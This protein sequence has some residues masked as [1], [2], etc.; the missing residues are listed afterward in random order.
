VP[1][2]DS[3]KSD[4]CWDPRLEVVNPTATQK[5]GEV[6]DTP[7]SSDCCPEGTLAAGTTYQGVGA[8]KAGAPSANAA[9]AP[10]EPNTSGPNLALGRIQERRPGRGLTLTD[11]GFTS[12]Q[13]RMRLSRYSFLRPRSG[14]SGPRQH[15]PG[16]RALAPR[17]LVRISHLHLRSWL[18]AHQLTRR[19][20]CNLLSMVD[21]VPCEIDAVAKRLHLR[22]D[23][24]EGRCGPIGGGYDNEKSH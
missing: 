9:Q 14:S 20:D 19:H 21:P 4:V 12:H 7:P 2:Q 3:A 8:A 17:A 11:R 10:R 5:V 18:L 15:G 23:S 13:R 16:P 1:S 6:H 22:R 24:V